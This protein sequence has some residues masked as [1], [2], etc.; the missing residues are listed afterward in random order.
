MSTNVSSA[1]SHFPKPQDGFTTTTSGSIS[2]GATTVGLNST[3]S[4]SSGDVFVGIIEP[5]VSG[6]EQT[7]TGIVDTSGV[8][9]TG[10]KWTRGTNVAHSAGVTVVD[11]ISA[12]HLGLISKGILVEHNQA[13]NHTAITGDSLNVTGAV[14]TNTISEK[15]A[16]NGVTVDGM[17]IKDG[18]V[19]G[20]SGTGIKNSSLDTTAGALG[21]A[22]TSWTPTVTQT[23]SVA[24]TNTSSEYIQIGKTVIARFNLEVTGSGT[25]NSAIVIG[26]LPVTASTSAGP[27]GHGFINNVD[28]PVIYGIT[29]QFASTTTLNGVW[30]GGTGTAAGVSP[31]FGFASGDTLIG[32]L[33]YEA[34]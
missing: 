31:N 23:G 27:A 15:T 13:G 34:A 8:Q 2:S 30:A 11:Y 25:G 4:Y 12:T 18:Y 28:V 7:F 9:I 17:N 6:K 10:V 33:I 19:V 3:G 16:A 5:G 29:W 1:S 20:G 22:W 32:I 26:A 14:T 21:G 24:V